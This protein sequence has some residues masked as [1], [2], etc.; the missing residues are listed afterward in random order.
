VGR[1][2][3]FKLDWDRRLGYLVKSMPETAFEDAWNTTVGCL[4]KAQESLLGG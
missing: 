1:K 3:D 4:Q 2:A